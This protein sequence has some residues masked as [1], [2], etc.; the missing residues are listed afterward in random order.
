MIKNLVA[1]DGSKLLLAQYPRPKRVVKTYN[2]KVSGKNVEV[3]VTRGEKYTY[4]TLDGIDYF[5]TGVLTEGASY[6]VE[7][8]KEEPAKAPA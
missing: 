4:L 5:I 2:I 6:K 8:V 1:A 3:V 7:N